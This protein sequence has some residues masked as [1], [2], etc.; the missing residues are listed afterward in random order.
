MGW[1]CFAGKV[2]GEYFIH[3]QWILSIRAKYSAGKVA[4]GCLWIQATTGG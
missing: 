4:G 2:A 3:F 1:E